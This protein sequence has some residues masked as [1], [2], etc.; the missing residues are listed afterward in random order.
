MSRTTTG[1]PRADSPNPDNSRR[2]KVVARKGG[3]SGPDPHCRDA[4]HPVAWLHICAPYGAE[5]S[6]TSWCQC[7]HRQHAAGHRRVLALTDTHA[8]H[9]DTCPLRHP[10]TTSERR[11]AA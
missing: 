6:A 4:R 8:T 7:G 3:R 10:A 11:N 2:A 5:P 1:V 9:R